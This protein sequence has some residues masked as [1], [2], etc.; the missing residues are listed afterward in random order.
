MSTA[1]PAPGQLN[2]RPVRQ[3]SGLRLMR[4]ACHA[5]PHDRSRDEEHPSSSV[6]LVE[7]GTFS[8]RTR[9]GYAHLSPGWL[10]LGDS[11]AGY[12]CSHEHSD[13]TGDDCV[14]LSVSR[15]TLDGA[16]S[17]LGISTSGAGFGR[18]AL[19]PTPR[20]TA[21]LGRLL[22]D[23]DQGFALEETALAV[24]CNVLRALHEGA[25]PSPVPQQDTRA[26]AAA[27]Y[28]ECHATE[29]LSLA[30]VAHA[31]GVSVFHLVR[32]FRRAIGVTPHQYLMRVRLLRAMSLL[33][34][35]A[36]PVTAI[37]YEVGWSDLSNF[38]RTF[39]RD[40]GCS[41]SGFRRGDKRML[42]ERQSRMRKV[43]LP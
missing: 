9:A 27:R 34:E 18:A 39:G 17:A 4:C 43:L 41:P 40:V 28:V 15:P 5:G 25:A 30:D 6:T 29:S 3:S 23:G 21:L 7:R 20:V 42:S 38:T 32:I 35:T 19:P 1:P 12:V 26:L 24:I 2:Y 13:G 22:L 10:M 36:M 8:Y 16:A 14:V 11:G 37:A 31:M 33:R